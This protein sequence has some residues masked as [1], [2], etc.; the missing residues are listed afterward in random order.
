[1]RAKFGGKIERVQRETTGEKKEEKI[2]LISHA[3]NLQTEL[4]NQIL[5]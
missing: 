4:L 2:K 1:M 5:N 3:G